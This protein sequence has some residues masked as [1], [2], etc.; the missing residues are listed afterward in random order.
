MAEFPLNM[1][2]SILPHLNQIFLCDIS[3]RVTA[4]GR[5][6]SNKEGMNE[7]LERNFSKLF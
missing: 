7:K 2:K 4:G 3:Q 5:H 6:E 1:L